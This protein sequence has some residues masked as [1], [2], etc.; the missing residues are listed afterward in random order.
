MRKLIYCISSG[1]GK[2]FQFFY[3]KSRLNIWWIFKVIYIVNS[4]RQ[5]F[6]KVNITSVFTPEGCL[7]LQ[8]FRSLYCKHRSLFASQPDKHL[9]NITSSLRICNELISIRCLLLELPTELK[10]ILFVKWLKRFKGIFSWMYSYHM[11][12]RALSE[13]SKR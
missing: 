2:V 12:L 9:W 11:H 6:S 8:L 10:H 4:K 5:C 3:R 1:K 13:V 7:N